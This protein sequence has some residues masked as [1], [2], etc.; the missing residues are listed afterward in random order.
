MSHIRCNKGVTLVELIIVIVIIGIISSITVLSVGAYVERAQL[1]AQVQSQNAIKTTLEYYSVENPINQRDRD[2]II[3]ALDDAGI[4]V[5]NPITKSTDI[6]STASAGS[7]ETAAIVVGTRGSGS[8][9]DLALNNQTTHVWPYNSSSSRYDDNDYYIGAVV[10]MV[11][12]DGYLIY[13][14]TK[15]KEF[16]DPIVVLFD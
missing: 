12:E 13:S 1:A 9:T 2:L 11:Y 16:H 8:R 7:Y 4:K 14:Y 15:D 5:T 3:D 10:I 6:I